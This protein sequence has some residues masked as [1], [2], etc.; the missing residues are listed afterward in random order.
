MST[1]DFASGSDGVGASGAQ[2]GAKGWP[3]AIQSPDKAPVTKES[4]S[5]YSNDTFDAVTGNGK[6]AGG[7]N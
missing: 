1:D 4:V 6:G 7:A 2:T 3:V 5:A